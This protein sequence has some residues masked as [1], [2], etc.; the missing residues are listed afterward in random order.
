MR[1]VLFEYRLILVI[2]LAIIFYAVF[3]WQ[4]FKV[5]AYKL[6][7]QAKSLAKDL[8][9]ASGEAQENGSLKK[10]MYYCQN[11]LGY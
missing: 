4:Q 11:H 7:L 9:L 5:L 3:Q 2:A 10:S 1:D 8:V 6:M